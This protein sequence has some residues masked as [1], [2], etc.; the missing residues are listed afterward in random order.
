MLDLPY[1]THRNLIEPLTGEKHVKLILI[2]RFLGFMEKITN[3]GKAALQMLM[4]EAKKDARSDT[5]SNYRNIMLLVDKTCVDD[6]HLE[7]SN[8]ISYCKLEA[9]DSWKISQIK[10]IVEAK[11]GQMEIPGFDNDE[12]DDLLDYLCTQ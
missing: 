11:A 3:S 6:V 8:L 9:H 10:E 2:R 1:A 7:D 12:L 5:G 4:L